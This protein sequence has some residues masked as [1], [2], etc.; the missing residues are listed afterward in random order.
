MDYPVSL[1]I[2][3]GDAV[4]PLI[5]AESYPPGRDTQCHAQSHVVHMHNWYADAAESTY[6][7][8]PQGLLTLLIPSFLFIQ[9]TRPR[10]PPS[11]RTAR[12]DPS[13]D[14][15]FV[16][17]PDNQPM[18]PIDDKFPFGLL[19]G[20]ELSRIRHCWRPRNLAVVRARQPIELKT[21]PLEA[22]PR[23]DDSPETTHSGKDSEHDICFCSL[24]TL[25]S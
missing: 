13:D 14:V 17:G 1:R 7:Q 8:Y 24:A 6:P 25:R 4:D 12:K 23:L 10:L 5:H 11:V 20:A 21:L 2:T 9:I 18:D 22:F 19:F 3:T 15:V 16:D